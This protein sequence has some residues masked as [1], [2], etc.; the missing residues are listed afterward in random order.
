MMFF[1]LP[2]LLLIPLAMMWMTRS[3]DDGAMSGCGMGHGGHTQ[4]A[5]AGEPDPLDI[6]RQRLARGDITASEYEEIHRAIM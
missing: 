4:T 2:L 6:A 1:W 5:V 3:S